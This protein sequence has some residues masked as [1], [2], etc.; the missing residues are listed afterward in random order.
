M[1]FLYQIS[2]DPRFLITIVQKYINI[3]L[4]NYCD[5]W[6]TSNENYAKWLK[7]YSTYLKTIFAQ[8]I[9]I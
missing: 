8:F 4:L 9:Q 2:W 7:K 5:Y 6:I 3:R 1:N